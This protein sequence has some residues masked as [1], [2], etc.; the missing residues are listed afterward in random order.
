MELTADEVKRFLFKHGN[1]HDCR[2]T[3]VAWSLIS[4][5]LEVWIADLN[6]NF[7]GLPEYS[8]LQPG[9]LILDGI[10]SIRVDVAPAS[11]RIYEIS[12]TV[13][14]ELQ[15]V[16]LLFAPSGKLIVHTAAVSIL[17]EK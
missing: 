9:R 2:V 5:R 6:A 16:E 11:D 3:D 12:F 14:G 4:N 17:Q 15:T 8:G 7:H 13:E 10:R 1:L